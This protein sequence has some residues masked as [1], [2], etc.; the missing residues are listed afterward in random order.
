[1]GLRRR[2]WLFQATAATTAART[3]GCQENESR[4]ID[5]SGKIIGNIRNAPGRHQDH[6]GEHR[7]VQDARSDDAGPGRLV[8]GR[9]RGKDFPGARLDR[10]APEPAEAGNRVGASQEPPVERCSVSCRD[11]VPNGA[12]G[13][14]RGS[15]HL[16]NRKDVSLNRHH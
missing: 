16:A 10:F 1:L 5:A 8:A 7:R 13:D 2:S 9:R 12:D 6:D 14:S 4:R 11:Q 15:R 3:R